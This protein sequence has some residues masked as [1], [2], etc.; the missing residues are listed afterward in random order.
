MNKTE[1]KREL[2]KLAGGEYRAYCEDVTI[3]NDGTVVKEFAVYTKGCG[4]VK[5]ASWQEA[6]DKLR[7]EMKEKGKL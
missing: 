4:Y 5:S 2:K 1:M 7:D 3:H 6:I